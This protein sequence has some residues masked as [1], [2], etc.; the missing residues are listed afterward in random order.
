MFVHSNEKKKFTY[1]YV[2]LLIIPKKKKVW[3]PQAYQ[4]QVPYYKEPELGKLE[5]H[6]RK[7]EKRKKKSI[8]LE[9]CIYK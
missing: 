5:Y 9:F 2:Y 7:K 3:G 1:F 6:R 4:T 8:T